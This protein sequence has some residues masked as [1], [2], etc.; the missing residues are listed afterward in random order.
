MDLYVWS[1]VEI[2]KGHKIQNKVLF[3]KVE[4]VSYVKLEGLFDYFYFVASHEISIAQSVASDL[5]WKHHIES[6][7][8][9]TNRVLGYIKRNFK[10]FP[11]E[12]K[13]QTP[14]TT[15]CPILECSHP[16]YGTPT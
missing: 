10:Q 9:K 4:S 7:V 16:Q 12:I 3:W 11:E 14:T 2:W 13:I 5:N 8:G 1:T 6:I 15:V